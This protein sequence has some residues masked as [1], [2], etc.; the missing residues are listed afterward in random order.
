MAVVTRVMVVQ[1]VVVVV[2]AV[3]N[4]GAFVLVGHG[5]IV[6]APVDG[7]HWLLHAGSSGSLPPPPPA[8]LL[9]L[10]LLLHHFRSP[11]TLS[12]STDHHDDDDSAVVVLASAAVIHCL[13]LLT[14]ARS[15]A[16][17][18][19]TSTYCTKEDRHDHQ[20]VPTPTS[21]LLVSVLRALLAHI[22]ARVGAD[23][24]T[25]GALLLLLLLLGHLE[26]INISPPPPCC[27]S[28]LHHV[29]VHTYVFLGGP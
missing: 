26:Q 1:Y 20:P 9:L 6:V 8:L 24:S 5:G 13:L 2:V 21:S 7:G 16:R 4:L 27:L 12:L 17:Q 22:Q 19:P 29:S 14:L 23:R 15:L 28:F 25:V 11:L 3:E 10:L 18:P